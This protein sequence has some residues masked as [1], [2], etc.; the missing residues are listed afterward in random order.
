MKIPV[1]ITDG[2]KLPTYANPG[3]AGMDFYS[4]EEAVLK[5]GEKRIFGTGAHMAIPENHVGLIWD[6]SGNAAKH[7][8]HVLAG[9]IDA[10]YRGEI[11]IVLKNLGDKEFTITKH[12]KIAQMLI[13]PVVSGAVEEVQ[14]LDDTVRGKGGFGS[15]GTH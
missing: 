8:I 9:V 3:D 6:R 14:E 11:G 13:Q 2:A 1:K 12:M 7:G 10:G 15:T 5:P 4:K